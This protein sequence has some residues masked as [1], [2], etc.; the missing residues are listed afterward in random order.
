MP[1]PQGL[2]LILSMLFLTVNLFD[3]D[4]I[5]DGLPLP[6]LSGG[7]SSFHDDLL[8]FIVWPNTFF[9]CLIVTCIV[10][11]S[12]AFSSQLLLPPHAVQSIHNT[13]SSPT[14]HPWPI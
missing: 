4:I 2:G 5:S 9:V 11:P 12:L 1:V 7:N 3:H 14:Q 10:L 8:T 13:F 6:L